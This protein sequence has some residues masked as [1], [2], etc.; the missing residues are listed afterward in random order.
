MRIFIDVGQLK[1]N[2]MRA[3]MPA[4]QSLTILR[5]W[6]EVCRGAGCGDEQIRELYSVSKTEADASLICLQDVSPREEFG[7]ENLETW[8]EMKVIGEM[9]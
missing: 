3:Q 6:D 2:A 4:S 9:N 7:L 8:L 1:E 5:K